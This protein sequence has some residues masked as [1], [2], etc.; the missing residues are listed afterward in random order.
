MIKAR[1]K[2]QQEE[3]E[4]QE[5]PRKKRK[6][7][8]KKGLRNKN[9]DDVTPLE[10]AKGALEEQGLTKKINYDQ[11]EKLFDTGGNG[12]D[13]KETAEVSGSCRRAR[14]QVGF[15]FSSTNMCLQACLLLN[16]SCI[17]MF[18]ISLISAVRPGSL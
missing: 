14:E 4:K 5:E 11:L 7:V 18:T 6:W 8:R 16:H 12:G 2:R 15:M 9:S 3:L 1:A 17:V 10:A 13:N